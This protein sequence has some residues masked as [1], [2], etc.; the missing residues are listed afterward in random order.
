MKCPVCGYTESKVI[1]SRPSEEGSSIRRR[2]ECLSCQNRFTTYE[3]IETLPLLVIKKDRTRELFDK[4]KLLSGI[5]KACHKRP[6]TMEQMEE[7]ATEIEAELQNSLTR[8]ISSQRIGVLV[9]DKL[10]SLDPVA[11]V[12]FASVYREFKDLDTFMR[13]LEQLRGQN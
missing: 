12:R 4:N 5:I 6:V 10:K 9:M 8:E 7:V 1:D 2:R 13:E 3:K 11:Y